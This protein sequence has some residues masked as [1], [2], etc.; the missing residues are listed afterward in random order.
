MTIL[1]TIMTTCDNSDNI[2]HMIIVIL[3]MFN[4][5]TSVNFKPSF[6]TIIAD[7]PLWGI[8]TL[9]TGKVILDIQTNEK[10]LISYSVSL[11]TDNVLPFR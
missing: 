10:C 6:L 2:D 5:D 11:F 4:K 7:G 8:P 3:A 9:F 1:T